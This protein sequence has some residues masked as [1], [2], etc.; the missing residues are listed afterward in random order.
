M[1]SGVVKGSDRSISSRLVFLRHASAETR[2]EHLKPRMI[3]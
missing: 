1:V 3:N 2:W